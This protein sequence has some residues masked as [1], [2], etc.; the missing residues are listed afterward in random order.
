MNWKPLHIPFEQHPKRDYITYLAKQVS[1]DPLLGYHLFLQGVNTP[2]KI[3]SFIF[4]TLIQC[5][6]P[7][8][9]N[10]MKPA[11]TRILQA[12][13][14]NEQILIYGDYDCDG[15]TSSAI[16]YRALRKLGAVVTVRLPIRSKGYGLS[17]EIIDQ[18]SDNISLLITVDNGSSAHPAM[19]RAKERGIDVIVTDHHEVLRGRPDCIAFINPKRSDSTYPFSSLSGTGVVLKVVQALCRE[20][21]QDWVRESLDYIEYVTLG[22]IADMMPLIG[23]NRIICWV[24]LYKMRVCPD[25]I[26][27]FLRIS[28]RLN[29]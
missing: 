10:E 3:Y 19:K 15:M 9:L 13:H 17:P 21:N 14:R 20:Q 16:L 27:H 29:T 24:G 23:E 25:P 26:F 1:L 11:V 8:L 12:I 6:N 5:H 7:F 18:L 4:P 2:E 28:Y 22:T